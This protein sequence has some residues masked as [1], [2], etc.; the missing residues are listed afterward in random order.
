MDVFKRFLTW[1]I[2]KEI[3]DDQQVVFQWENMPDSWRFFLFLAIVALL[4]YGIYWIY[5]REIDTC[6]RGVKIALAAL[7]VLTLA[8]LIVLFLQ[9]SVATLTTSSRKPNIV[10]I[11]DASQSMDR[12]DQYR[13]KISE[14]DDLAAG[15]PNAENP[16]VKMAAATGIS[17][18]ELQAGTVKRTDIVN[19]L[20]SRKNHQ[21]INDLREKG[22]VRVLKFADK[23]EDMG[24]LP[25]FTDAKKASST[26]AKSGETDSADENAGD[27]SDSDGGSKIAGLVGSGSSSDIWQALKNSLNVNQLAAIVLISD[28]QHTTPDDP[29]EIAKR[30]KELGVPVYVLGVGDPGRPKNLFVS[31]GDDPELK[32]DRIEIASAEERQWLDYLDQV[33]DRDV[34]EES[35][36]LFRTVIHVL[37]AR[38]K[39]SE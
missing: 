6:P 22:A 9:P 32:E 24:T 17:A 19:K 15:D 25:A 5:R 36:A 23:V 3:G 26:T 39:D 30:A 20:L 11:E 8:V 33:D 29:V 4:V 12:T 18:T 28:G 35:K 38:Q 1:L 31:D 14:S 7:R 2:G 37:R 13:I 34:A 10:L 21:F 16:L 27:A